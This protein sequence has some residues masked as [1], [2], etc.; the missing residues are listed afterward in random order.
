MPMNDDVEFSFAW[1]GK[2]LKSRSLP[3][4]GDFHLSTSRTR[5][6]PE[7]RLR[8]GE[9]PNILCVPAARHHSKA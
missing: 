3:V 7:A 8:Y 2:S 9:I 4:S 5:H 1:K 6:Q